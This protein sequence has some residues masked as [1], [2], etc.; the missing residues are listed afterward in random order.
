[1]GN[2]EQIEPGSPQFQPK[3]TVFDSGVDDLENPK[4][5]IVWS[6]HMNTYILP[7]YVVSFTVP[8]QLQGILLEHILEH[9]WFLVFNH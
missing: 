4:W 7:E 8:K 9:I 1:M 2:M 3:D 6:T 5:Y